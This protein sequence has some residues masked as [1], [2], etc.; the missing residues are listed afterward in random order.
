MAASSAQEPLQSFLCPIMQEV[1]TDPVCTIDGHCY[2][3]KAISTWFEKRIT[4]PLTG[5]VLGSRTL[6]PNH[7]L[8]R[9][10]HEWTHM[11]GGDQVQS[12]G[13][14]EDAA[15]IESK[16]D[17]NGDDDD[18]TCDGEGKSESEAQLGRVI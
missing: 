18:D 2:E 14:E 15:P 13:E 1:M 7:A 3:K 9:A 4:S 11:Y 8:R 5:T 17:D 12:A 16:N 10:I 6:I